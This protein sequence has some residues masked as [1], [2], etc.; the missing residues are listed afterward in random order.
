MVADFEYMKENVGS[1]S[2]DKIMTQQ[3]DSETKMKKSCKFL[4]PPI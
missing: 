2:I 1:F 4:N 3:F